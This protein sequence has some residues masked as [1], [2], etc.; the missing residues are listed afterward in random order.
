MKK[1][2]LVW[3]L[4]LALLLPTLG[5][6]AGAE[7]VT[8]STDRHYG[9]AF[10]SGGSAAYSFELGIKASVRITCSYDKGLSS[11]WLSKAGSAAQITPRSSYSG[12]DNYGDEY[13][14]DVD[15]FYDLEPGNYNVWVTP[16]KEIS[17]TLYWVQVSATYEAHTHSYDSTEV[18][19]PTC[20][21]KGYTKH[22]CDCGEYTKDD[23]TDKLPHTEA[24]AAEVPATCQ[25]TGK[26]A[27]TYCSVCDTTLSGRDTTPKTGHPYV[28]NVCPHCGLAAGSCGGNLKWVLET[29]GTLT[30]FGSGAMYDYGQ[31]GAPWSRVSGGVSAVNLPEGLTSIGANAFANCS[32]IKKLMLP[33]AVTAIGEQA[34]RGVTATIHYNDTSAAMNKLAEKNYGGSLS[35][36][37]SHIY[38]SENTPATCTEQG[39]TT[40]SCICGAEYVD[41][42]VDAGHQISN[43]VCERCGKI[44]TCGDNLTWKFDDKTGTLTISGK[45][46]M[47]N[48]SKESYNR[49]PW[50]DLKGALTGLVVEKGV[51]SIGDYAFYNSHIRKAQLPEGL[52][53]IGENAFC[54]SDNLKECN[55]PNSVTSIGYRAFAYTDLREVNIP[56]NVTSAGAY[57]FEECDNLRKATIDCAR[58]FDDMFW[59]C[60]NLKEVILTDNVKII[61]AGTFR[62]CRNLT[63]L[64][65]PDS[66]T[67]IEGDSLEQ[68]NPNST[69]VSSAF[70]GCGFVSINIPKGV[71]YIG[72]GAFADC[73][74]LTSIIIPSSVKN[75]RNIF[76]GC[77]SLQTV[78]FQG[79]VCLNV[80]H[81]T[82]KNVTAEV[83]YPAT[84][85]SDWKNAINTYNW[86]GDLTWI[87]Y[88]P[89]KDHS[90]GS[91]AR[92]LEPKCDRP[93]YE[94]RYCSKCEVIEYKSISALGHTL[95]IYKAVA[96]TCTTD[97]KTEGSY[98]TTCRTT[99]EEQET[100]KALGHSW[101]DWVDDGMGKYRVCANCDEKETEAGTSAVNPFSDVASDA[102]Y[103]SPV[104]WAVDKGI[105]NGM[106]ATHFAP[107]GTCTRAQIVTFL[108]RSCGSPKPASGLNPFSDVA[109]GQWYTDAVLW[110]MEK[111]ITTGTSDN[112][113]SP[114]AGCTRG[115]V[116]TFLWRSQGLP[117]SGGS[118]IFTDIGA[119]AY[120]Y[121]AVLWAVA[122]NITNGM[123]DG[124]FAPDATCTRGQIVT[125]LFR[126][127]A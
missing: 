56:A 46:K 8:E 38:R 79:D 120:Y 80:L 10:Y 127:M 66:I 7:K 52:Q 39:Y 101:G 4:L 40:H 2:C 77:T 90:Y 41:S 26:T 94:S 112:T 107:D 106:D 63:E 114:D 24:W 21:A 50:Y 119:G 85:A 57:V 18:V 102:Y 115:Q 82:F 69:H 49:A 105:T 34:F 124:T 111:G 15:L 45:G 59:Y 44:G 60:D 11:V 96:A 84:Y 93:G 81:T 117:A 65:L 25:K 88:N 47:K 22:I 108:W 58:T 23:Y 35:W 20:S 78:Y 71:T 89:C 37:G 68:P 73:E 118:N 126:A 31:E 9:I 95:K 32:G 30:I 33:E 122:N 72:A 3:M 113:F 64:V 83:Y 86:G 53:S 92:M 1:R 54:S 12:S 27:G 61:G 123:G 110:A 103:A 48:Y 97:G 28:N 6:E 67:R 109:P 62:E 99:I 91:W 98:C 14:Y 76:E 29:D 19:P 87:E 17:S 116:A 16:H 100:V 51:T 70:G 74:N 13:K 75:I 121:D 43:G 125:F 5:M 104:V 55:I 42:Y 36:G